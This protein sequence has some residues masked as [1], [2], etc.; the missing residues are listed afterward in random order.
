MGKEVCGDNWFE[1]RREG[2]ETTIERSEVRYLM[3]EREARDAARIKT[4]RGRVRKRREQEFLEDRQGKQKREE[5]EE[6]EEEA[7]ECEKTGNRAWEL[8]FGGESGVGGVVLLWQ[9][10]RC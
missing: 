10:Y 7:D 2:S 5:E 1:V 9:S 3:T 6:D 4:R 8:V